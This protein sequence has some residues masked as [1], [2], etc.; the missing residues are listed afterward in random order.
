M[1]KKIVV[2]ILLLML[3]VGIISLYSTFAYD[4]ENSILSNSSADYN[5][6]YSI[7]DNSN[8]RVTLSAGE[9]KYVDISLKNIYHS[10]VKYGMYYYLFSEYGKNE[11]SVTLAEDSD[12]ILEDIIKPEGIKNISLKLVNNSM[13]TIDAQVGALIGFENGKIEDLAKNGEILIK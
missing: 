4:S 8:K 11:L 5:L 12:D 3:S 10:P 9:E 1:N 2:I 13:Y 6:I 7:S